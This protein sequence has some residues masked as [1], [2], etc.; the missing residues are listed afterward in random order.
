MTFTLKNLVT[1]L[2]ADILTQAKKNVT[3]QKKDIL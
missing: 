1:S 3:K 2:S